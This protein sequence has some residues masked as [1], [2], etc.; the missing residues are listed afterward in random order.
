MPR[1]RPR[2]Q[3]GAPDLQKAGGENEREKTSSTNVRDKFPR[4]GSSVVRAYRRP[5]G[6]DNHDRN[7]ALRTIFSICGEA[8]E[9]VPNGSQLEPAPRVAAGDGFAAAGR[10]GLI[11]RFQCK[12]AS[13]Q[14]IA[15]AS[16]YPVGLEPVADVASSYRVRLST[17]TPAADCRCRS[18]AEPRR[19]RPGGFPDS[20]V[21]A[22]DRRY[23]PATR[24]RSFI[25]MASHRNTWSC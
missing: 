8:S 6:R 9:N 5:G 24:P 7:I 18:S 20:S 3:D 11:E 19:G 15:R 14:W 16:Y 4:Y 23:G 10:G 22:L 21:V 13:N 2:P 25:M 1:P 17:V 12:P